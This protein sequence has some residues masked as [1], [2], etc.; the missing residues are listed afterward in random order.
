MTTQI[1]RPARIRRRADATACPI[2]AEKLRR[3][4]AEAEA[5]ADQAPRPAS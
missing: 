4:A 1:D 5:I 2:A 3:L